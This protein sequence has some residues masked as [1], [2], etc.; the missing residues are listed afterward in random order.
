MYFKTQG[1]FKKR[2]QKAFENFF[3]K[4]LFSTSM[5]DLGSGKTCFFKKISI[6][7]FLEVFS[8]FINNNKLLNRQSEK[9]HLLKILIVF[10]LKILRFYNPNIDCFNCFL[11]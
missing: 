10:M 8:Y 3:K 9:L 11:T 1:H 5:I 4:E 2:W 7:R 6:L